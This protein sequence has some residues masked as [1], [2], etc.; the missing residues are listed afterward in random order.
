[1]QQEK[2]AEP[3]ADDCAAPPPESEPRQNE[4]RA[5]PPKLGRT[6][7]DL[8]AQ[9]L[10]QRRGRPPANWYRRVLY[11]LVALAVFYLGYLL[12]SGL[13]DMRNGIGGIA[14]NVDLIRASA[15]ATSKASER[16]E[17]QFQSIP[18][19]S[20]R[21][22][23][24]DADVPS[25]TARALE[26]IQRS[27]ATNIDASQT[28]AITAR[29]SSDGTIPLSVMIICTPQKVAFV[30]VAGRD[31]EQT[32]KLRDSLGEEFDKSPKQK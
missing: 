1:M 22:A 21:F 20:T 23:A 7:W 28:N 32:G 17:K 11:L 14:A 31:D 6:A 16:L 2:T 9:I 30:V 10:D 4:P 29:I 24:L 5:E 15:T 12:L 19:V 13:A 26:A 25:C 3:I 27:G 18:S 8:L